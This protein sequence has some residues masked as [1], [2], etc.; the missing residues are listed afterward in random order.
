MA[1]MWEVG[2]GFPCLLLKHRSPSS[3]TCQSIVSSLIPSFWVFYGAQSSAPLFTQEVGV[4]ACVHAKLL[5]LCLTLGPSGLQPARL[6]CPW[7]SPGKNTGVGCHAHSRGSTQPRFRI[8]V[9][10]LAG[11]FF[12]HLSHQGSPRRLGKEANPL[13]TWLISLGNQP[14]ALKSHGIN[15]NSG[16]VG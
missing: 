13:I 6:L 14:T 2:T 15:I 16:V 4:H 10:C 7:D 8:S 5:Q 1:V 9:S 3:S 12:Y 11:R